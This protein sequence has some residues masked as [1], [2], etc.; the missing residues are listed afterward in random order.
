MTEQPTL[1]TADTWAL[2]VL[3]SRHEPSQVGESL[4]IPAGE[5]GP[6]VFGRGA[7]EGL[8][9]RLLLTRWTHGGVAVS[10]TVTCPRISRTQL[11]LSLTSGETLLL[12]NRGS[13]SLVYQGRKRDHVQLRAG[14][15][16]WLH[17]ELLFLCVR[18]PGCPPH[19]R[20][21]QGASQHDWGRPDASGLV[22]ESMAMWQLRERIA[23]ASA[24]SSHVLLLGPSGTGKELVAQALHVQSTRGSRPIVSRNAVTIPEGI[25]DAE[26]FGNLRNYPNVGTPERSGLIGAAHESTLFLDEIA[27]LPHSIQAHLLR[28]L[29]Q[30][31]YQRLGETRA[32]RADLRVIGATNRPATALKHDLLARF[33]LRI[34]LPDLNARRED[35]PL[36]VAHLLRRQAARD[37]AVLE[38]FFPDRDPRAWPRVSPIFI[39]KLVTHDFTTNVRELESMLIA[40]ALTNN[41]RYLEASAAIGRSKPPA[42]ATGGG[43]AWLTVEETARLELLRKH[44]FS[45]TACGRDV[46]YR[47]NRQTAD[48][49]FR[50]IA[51]KAL[52]DCDWDASAAAMLLAGIG[53]APLVEKC[54]RR[55][56]RF[57]SNLEARVESEPPEQLHKALT[58]DWKGLV[59]AV[60]PLVAAIRARAKGAGG[61]IQ[62]V[63]SA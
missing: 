52:A 22:G 58:E 45:P 17:N 57:L 36:L 10:R 3:W 19:S 30:G 39:E 31:E 6:W 29:D 47:G 34:T 9:R 43:E 53:D 20:V 8:D 54:A 18:R 28:V 44:R 56:R 7:G 13:C 24:V 33:M 63:R 21:H 14:D 46:A 62:P 50:H 48:L 11:R 60:L 59:G 1:G 23:A 41:G 35:I 5:R 61:S 51:C 38:R 55:L 16:V 25:A 32:R 27:E 49:H 4:L 42:A 15:I 12:E 2:V 26:L 40:A 37:Q